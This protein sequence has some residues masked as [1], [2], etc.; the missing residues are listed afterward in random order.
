MFNFS[1]ISSRSVLSLVGLVIVLGAGAYY[2][3][4]YL[5]ESEV[6][7]AKAAQTPVKPPI[8]VN[9]PPN[10]AKPQV[11]Q[12][13]PAASSVAA[14]PVAST[15]VAAPVQVASADTQMPV[16]EQKP[17]VVKPQAVAKKPAPKKRKVKSSPV[18]PAKPSKPPGVPVKLQEI[19]PPV[20]VVIHDPVMAAT[21]PIII[22]PKYNDMLTAALHGDR[23]AVRQLLELGRWVDKPGE[24]GLTPLIAAIMNR[25]TQMVQ[26][27][28]DNG[29]VPTV[30]ALELAQKNKDAAIVSLLQ[31]HNAQ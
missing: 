10:V 25:D 27:L 1:G 28:L 6:K 22:T 2:Y 9:N 3:F 8:N 16:S 31:Q 11:V 4:V 30:K 23:D 5:P 18:R 29:A 15:P 20:P 12:S 19:A 24:S 17:E 14:L 13:P 26:L 7:P 21:E